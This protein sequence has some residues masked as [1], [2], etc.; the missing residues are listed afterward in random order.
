MQLD[1]DS[2]IKTGLLKLPT[3][4]TRAKNFLNH[5]DLAVT[6]KYILTNN[7]SPIEQSWLKPSE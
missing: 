5:P 6:N 7:N 3:F 2:L 4:A 1:A